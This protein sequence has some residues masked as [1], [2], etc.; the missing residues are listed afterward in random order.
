MYLLDD[1]FASLDRTVVD[2]IWKEAVMGM[3]K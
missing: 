1:P 2:H 3:L